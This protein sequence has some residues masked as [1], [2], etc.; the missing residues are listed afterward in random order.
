[1]PPDAAASVADPDP[2]AKCPPRFALLEHDQSTAAAV[3]PAARG[4]HW[5]FL[6]ART[7][8]GPLDAWRLAA[9]PLAVQAPIVAT[10]L[11]PHRPLYLDYEGPIGGD[12]GHVR[13]LD[14]GHATILAWSA[15]RTR[16]ELAGSNLCGIFTLASD[17]VGTWWWQP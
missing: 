17:A 1:M 6:L 15:R 5:D 9:N 13:R 14:R 7:S 4:V 2:G 11:P 10:P 12:R 16:F 8:D 3:P